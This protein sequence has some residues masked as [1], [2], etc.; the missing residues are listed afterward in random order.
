MELYQ[1][2]DVPKPVVENLWIVD[3]PVIRFYRLPFPTRMTVVRL[4]SG[5]LILNS[6]TRLSEPLAEAVAGLGRVAHLVAPNWIHYASVPA[7]KA[8]FPEAVTWAAPG[9][10]ARAA[11][12][13]IYLRFDRALGDAAPADWAAELDQMLVPGSAV[14]REV[15]FFHKVGRVLILTDLI[16]NFEPA[17]MPFWLRPLLRLVG[18]ADPDGK[19]PW[20]MAQTFRKHRDQLRGAVERMIGWA[21][22]HI[23]LAHGRCYHGDGAAELRRAFRRVLA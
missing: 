6:P 7:W 17:R 2:L 16:E 13:G 3:G 22:E 11:K 8:R 5:D 15:V 4:A 1:P 20:D 18:I 23:V 10:E 14:H 21:P 12:H 9:V 19:M